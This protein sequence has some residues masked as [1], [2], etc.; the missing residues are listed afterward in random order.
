MI[1]G[2]VWYISVSDVI[3]WGEISLDNCYSRNE[4]TK[5]NITMES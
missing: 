1:T 5:Y 3:V 4:N 2:Q